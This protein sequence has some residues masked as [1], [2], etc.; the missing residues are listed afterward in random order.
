MPPHWVNCAHF[1]GSRREFEHETESFLMRFYRDHQVAH[2]L[3][4]RGASNLQGAFIE[5]HNGN[6]QAAMSY[7]EQAVT[8]LQQTVQQWGVVLGSSRDLQSFLPGKLRPEF[9]QL[10]TSLSVRDLTETLEASG[11]SP[12]GFTAPYYEVSTILSGGTEAA[13]VSLFSAS[14]SKISGLRSLSQDILHILESLRDAV[15]QGELW[16]TVVPDALLNNKAKHALIDLDEKYFALLMNH[17]F[18]LEAISQMS[19]K[20][21]IESNIPYGECKTGQMQA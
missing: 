9:V 10:M 6:V 14:D 8:L 20:V 5:D 1:C 11:N 18:F 21:L 3:S 12:K 13:V 17:A 7:Y 19:R 2:E 4:N 16:N 15:G